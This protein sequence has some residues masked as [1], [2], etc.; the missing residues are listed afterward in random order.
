M[1]TQ[2]SVQPC[3][4]FLQV[5]TPEVELLDQRE[6][7]C[8][9]FWG[10]TIL[11][12]QGLYHFTQQQY[13]N[14]STSLSTL[15]IVFFIITILLGMKWYLTVI[16]IY[17]SLMTNNVDIFSCTPWLFVYLFLKKYLFRTSLLVKWIR[18]HLP[19]QWTPFDP[20]PRKIPHASGQLSLLAAATEPVHLEPMLC[21]KRSPEMRSLPT[22]TRESLHKAMRPSTA[23]E[24][25]KERKSFF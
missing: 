4:Q 5:C 23:K 20:W 13:S 18:F 9:F 22:A 7:L 3:S 2:T 24:K 14:F 12:P 1:G 11:F 15:V 10:T 25:H 8:L 16:F 17:I 19:M 6:I 21:S